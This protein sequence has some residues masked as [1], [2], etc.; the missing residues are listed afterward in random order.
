MPL[1]LC[2]PSQAYDRNT[3]HSCVLIYYTNVCLIAQWSLTA[4]QSIWWLGNRQDN[5][6]TGIC[7]LAVAQS[8][9]ASIP[10]CDFRRKSFHSATVI[11]YSSS[12]IL[13]VTLSSHMHHTR[14]KFMKTYCQIISGASISRYREVPLRQQRGNI[15]RRWDV[16]MW[17]GLGWP[18]I[19]TG[20]GR[21]WVW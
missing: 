7:F 21:L 16:S 2:A 12:G 11:Q 10:C 15:S 18:R 20:G 4:A 17:T 13:L 1:Q 8:S 14:L 3:Q 19:G 6:R 9:T 5:Q